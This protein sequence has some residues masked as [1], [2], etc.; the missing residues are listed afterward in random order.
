MSL[1]EADMWYH[2]WMALSTLSAV[3]SL[4]AHPPIS[5]EKNLSG[6]SLHALETYW[7][8]DFLLSRRTNEIKEV[9]TQSLSRA[10]LHV[11]TERELNRNPLIEQR[12][13]SQVSCTNSN[14]VKLDQ[15]SRIDVETVEFIPQ[16]QLQANRLVQIPTDIFEAE[17][18]LSVFD[19]AGAWGPKSSV[20]RFE[21]L[22]RLRKYSLTAGWEWVD[23]ILRRSPALGC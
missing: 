16:T 19:C 7:T 21:R 17:R 14:A 3:D 12:V 20:T 1:T 4:I 8:N 18:A 23:D 13:V 9:I 2:G 22:A 15:G 6:R 10:A 11:P 5:T